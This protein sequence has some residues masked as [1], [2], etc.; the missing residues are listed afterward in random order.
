ME[1]FVTATLHRY[2]WRF[3]IIRYAVCETLKVYKT[4]VNQLL[5]SIRDK[6]GPYIKTCCPVQLRSYIYIYPIWE[7]SSLSYPSKEAFV[8][9]FLGELTLHAIHLFIFHAAQCSFRSQ[10]TL[11]V[12]ENDDLRFKM[13]RHMFMLNIGRWHL[14]WK[15]ISFSIKEPFFTLNSGQNLIF[16]LPCHWLLLHTRQVMISCLLPVWTP[17]SKSIYNREPAQ[18]CGWASCI[19]NLHLHWSVIFSW[20]FIWLLAF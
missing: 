12:T 13:K 14:L 20:P 6:F 4:S 8:K 7:L 5:I 17:L 9:L 16:Y 1:E 15:H 10:I 3:F 11:Y 2:L 18:P 19:Q